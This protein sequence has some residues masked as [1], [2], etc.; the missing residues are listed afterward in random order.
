MQGRQTFRGREGKKL[1]LYM[2]EKNSHQGKKINID[3][4]GTEQTY[5]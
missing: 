4:Y 2:K 5:K 3:F 1:T